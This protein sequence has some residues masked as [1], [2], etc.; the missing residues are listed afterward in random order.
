[1]ENS[2]LYM[3]N[4]L[5]SDEETIKEFCNKKMADINEKMSEFCSGLIQSLRD[6]DVDEEKGRIE[7][8]AFLSRQVVLKD[9]LGELEYHLSAKVLFAKHTPELEE[10]H[11]VA[12]V[13]D[14]KLGMLVIYITSYQFG[15]VDE[16]Y[17]SFYDSID[18]MFIDV[19]E[20]L[21]ENILADKEDDNIV[22]EE[23]MDFTQLWKDF[24]DNNA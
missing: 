9:F 6:N 17:I 14:D 18:N 19:K 4:E 20:T 1:M 2:S 5:L 15:V 22:F 24:F 8:N 10:Q 13:I 16:L 7:T 21:A 3:L 23:T 12:Y 11:A